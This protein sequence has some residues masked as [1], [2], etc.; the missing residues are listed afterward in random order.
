MDLHK[1]VAG[2]G[3]APAILPELAALPEWSGPP[4][5]QITEPSGLE[6]PPPFFDPAKSF[7]NWDESETFLEKVFADGAA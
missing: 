4:P 2:M 6:I 1:T 5:R 3:E 7:P